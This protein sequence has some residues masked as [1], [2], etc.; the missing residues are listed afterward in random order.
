[1]GIALVL[2]IAATLAWWIHLGQGQRTQT[3][4]G[5]GG[6]I[7]AS[8]AAAIVQKGD[9]DI[10]LNALGTVTSLSTVTVKAQVSGQLIKVAFQ[11]GQTVKQG[12][13]LAEIDPRPFEATVAQ[14]QGQ[15]DRDQALLSGAKVDLVRYQKLATT[16]A[17]PEQ[18][19]DTQVALV[20]QYEGQVA[21]DQG[22]LNTAKVNLSFTR[23]LSPSNGRAGL[24]QVDQGNYVTANDPN[25]IVVVTQIQPISVIFT[26]PEDNVPA[27]LKR[28]HGGTELPVTVFDRS[29]TNQLG[30][31]VLTTLDNQIDQTT[32][33]VKLRAQFPNADETLFPNQ[34][35]N[36]RLLVDMIHDAVVMPS[37]AVQRGAPG[38][39]VYLVNPNNTVSVRPVELGPVDGE[40]VVVRKGLALNERV[41]VDGADKLRDGIRINIRDAGAAKVSSDNLEQGQ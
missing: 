17:V 27:I 37:S 9:V 20:K 29:G 33:T 36:V 41:V 4:K 28:F 32:G 34:F 13:L 19:L 24:R 6:G 16:H 10:A 31:G 35:V 40:R 22:Q 25:G 38:T 26:V 7:P 3:G 5:K 23:I 15:L 39:F 12:D 8:V 21:A 30:A 14:M 11:E 2:A 1:M 18:Q